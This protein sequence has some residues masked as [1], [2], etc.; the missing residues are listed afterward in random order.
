MGLLENFAKVAAGPT[1]TPARK[2]RAMTAAGQRI[3]LARP[4]PVLNRRTEWQTSAWD[5]R[6]TVPELQFVASFVRSSLGRLRVFPAER[7]PRGISPQPL[8]RPPGVTQGPGADEIELDSDIK[9]AVREA[10]IAASSRLNLDQ[11]GSTLLARLGENLEFAGE[12]YLLGEDGDEGETWSIRSVSEVQIG[13]GTVR[14]V[15]PG[16]GA[17]GR[18]LEPGRHELLRLWN[19]HPRY[20]QWPDSPIAALL[21]TCE[22]MVLL[23]RRGRAHDR[24]RI[25]KGKA[26]FLPWELSLQRAGSA[27]VSADAEGVDE[28]DDPF[29][30]ELTSYMMTPIT[31]DADPSAIVPLI[32]RGQTHTPDGSALMK[33]AIGTVDLHNDDPKDLDTRR[34]NLV[35]I[36]ARGIDLPPEVLTGIGDTN[37]WNGAVIS[38]ETVKS[39]IEPRAER[40]VDALTVAY[41]WP[42]LKAMGFSR[43][44]REKVCL[45]FDPSELMQD[46]DRGQAAKDAHES[47]VISDATM[48][49]AL[50]FTDEDKPS[51]MEKLTRTLTEGRAYEASIPVLIALSGMDLQDPKIKQAMTLAMNSMFNPLARNDIQHNPAL[52]MYGAG[53][54]APSVPK[55]QRGGDVTGR[56]NG[57]PPETNRAG[58][59]AP[60]RTR[61]STPRS[62]PPAVRASATRTDRDTVHTRVSQ[63]LARI[64]HD[65]MVKLLAHA[66][67]TVGRA[68]EKA[69]NRLRNQARKNPL[70]A[71]A[72]PTGSDP[73]EVL[74]HGGRGLVAALDDEEALA[75]ALDDYAV[76]FERDTS[77]AAKAVEQAVGQIVGPGKA[78]GLADRLSTRARDA[79]QWLKGRL[80]ERIREVLY[81]ENRLTPSESDSDLVP[82]SLIRGAVTQIGGLPEGAAGIADDGRLV[83]GPGDPVRP[84]TGPGT[85]TLVMDVMRGADAQV[86]TW[87][88]D[89]PSNPRAHFEPHRALDGLEFSSWTDPLLDAGAEASWIGPYFHPGDHQGCL[90]MAT[91][92]WTTP[93]TVPEPELEGVG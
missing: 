67:A 50:G 27:P 68:V 48:R 29:M 80:Q 53:A 7:R 10:A 92:I 78:R 45:W 76:Q 17:G 31:N 60:D 21:E 63:R 30:D 44:E 41:L 52:D 26:L 66:D 56:A 40:M 24:S 69:A 75:G 43:A 18:D 37:H 36:L 93:A 89:Y 62:A 90:C 74:A 19:P 81:G 58:N 47:G 46:P 23:S 12:A 2:P 84:A 13:N 15:D 3:D 28:D 64:D 25:S 61:P 32:V 33:D 79:W 71:A 11:H 55:A 49:R 42:A 73:R 8:D 85:G 65:L 16:S 34:D 91:P 88:W 14:L 59:R 82:A 38:A 39:H 57:R 35:A 5:Y 4:T 6:D 20:E 77:A 70:T 22:A 1:P 54:G 51:D 86:A 83:R 9:P 87:V 72:F